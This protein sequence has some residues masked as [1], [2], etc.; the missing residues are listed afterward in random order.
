MGF[1]IVKMV[2]KDLI[3]LLAFV[4]IH[5]IIMEHA[6]KQELVNA[7]QDGREMNAVFQHAK[8]IVIIMEIAN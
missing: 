4:L 6:L 3:A 7:Y 1:A 8:T 2:G 5:V